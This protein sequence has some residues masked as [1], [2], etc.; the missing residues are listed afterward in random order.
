MSINIYK[1]Q[2][3][4]AYLFGAPV[5]YHH[6]PI[7]REDVPQGWFCYDLRGTAQNPDRTYCL[8]DQAEKNYAGS[9]L[10]YLTLKNGR[11]Q[12]RL[13]KGMFQMT[14]VSVSLNQ[15]CSDEKIAAPEVPLRHT[16][17]PASPED[18]GLFYALTPEE[19]A[20][21]GAIGHVRMDFGHGGQEFWHTWWPRG[22]EE[23]NTPEFRDELNKVVND[24]RQGVL[25][26]LSSMRRYCCGSE[27]AIAGGSCCQ[28]YGFTLETDRYLYRLRCNPA[29]DDY[30]GYLTIFDKQV[31]ELNQRQQMKQSM[32]MGGM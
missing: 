9:I 24:L 16:L 3:Q 15:F 10:S 32:T 1:D 26:D 31:Q 21:L 11:S 25:K 14:C 20:E 22:P 5:L 17:C 6:Q 29:K 8:V 19:D 18:A 23:L 2:M 13:I 12:S 28:N 4:K 27:G 7:P 30:Q